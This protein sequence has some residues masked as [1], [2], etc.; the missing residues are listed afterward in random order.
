[1]RRAPSIELSPEERIHL[2]RVS[3]TPGSPPA[4]VRAR[5]VLAAAGG[6]TNEEIARTLGI[7]RL[8]VGRWRNRFQRSRLP[9]LN[10]EIR[11]ISPAARLS[12]STIQ[13]IVR[14]TEA[15]PAPG[16]R[17]W[18]T[19]A[20]ARRF[21][22][23]HMTVQ[24]IWQAHRIRPVRF[25]ARPLRAD[26][27]TPLTVHDV[28]GLFLNY[29][30]GALALTLGP[31]HTAN[32]RQPPTWARPPGLEGNAGP[33]AWPGLPTAPSDLPRTAIPR[34]GRVRGEQLLRFL[35]GASRAAG[36]DGRLRVVVTGPTFAPRDV[37][38]TWQ[39]RHPTAEI[40]VRPG[41]EA[42][43]RE[44]IEQIRAVGR[45]PTRS[46]R[47]RTRGETAGS[48]VRFLA[49]YPERSG[50]YVWLAPRS[51]PEA[52]TAA[53]R[54]RYDLSVTGHPGFKSRSAAR[55]RMAPARAPTADA[56]EMARTVLRR[57]LRVKRGE[58]VAIA[59]W[60]SSLSE[61]NA[62]V[63][64]SLALGARPF[65]LY[66][67]EPTY[68]AAAATTPLEHL[69]HLGTHQ[70]AAI[71]RS[72]AL[73]SF[74]GPSD[75]ERFH[76]LPPAVMNRLGAF[77][78]ELYTAVAR[79]GARAV[80]MALGRA[81]AASARMYGVNLARWRKELIDGCR[82]DPDELRRRGAPLVRKLATGRELRITHP[83]GTDLV[84]RLRHRRPIL[85]DGVATAAR[86][87]GTW[88]LVTLPAGVVTVAVDERFAEGTFR[89]NVTSSV[90]LSRGVGEFAGGRW[91]FSRGRLARY[92][93]DTGGELFAESYANAGAGRE[94]P[95][96]VAIGLNDAISD[97][98]LL[99]DQGLG[100]VT[101]HIGRND[102]LGGS[103]AASWW[104]WL[105]LR[106][107]DLAVDGAKLVSKGR[108]RP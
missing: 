14:A 36:K 12:S 44:A 17:G 49:D 33:T 35:M 50:P 70:R 73:V 75:R 104:A 78:D 55:E 29:P 20:L 80:Q 82:V 94:R 22:V 90:G 18:T 102:Y 8:A 76:A 51:A 72:D 101:L 68:W 26:P 60:T 62:F 89:S 96:S 66:Q 24:R 38:A 23:S 2:E 21:S 85:A 100:T 54:L 91:T 59:C 63:L 16:P 88:S 40:R 7:G 27:V 6:A 81:S 10:D 108:L 48:L 67:D 47:L 39:L 95:G 71:E 84:L 15:L 69:G 103:N 99:E 25:G 65:L 97:S 30:E 83:N 41:W 46:N 3:E 28:V 37:V 105:Y 9:G 34:G 13:A 106:G 4:V 42:W 107:A 58:Q 52:G 56:R 92:T 53:H 77:D 79:G 57:S 61:A 86:P 11:V 31:D 19:R 32:N 74:F 5:I 87:K 93:Y 1:M 45:P 98:P 64:E 43:K